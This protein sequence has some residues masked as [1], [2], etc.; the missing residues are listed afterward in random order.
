MNLLCTGYDLTNSKRIEYIL[1][2]LFQNTFNQIN[3]LQCN[4]IKIKP[5]N[6]FN[7]P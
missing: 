4:N 2:K 6:I 5:D 3:L 7:T 1:S